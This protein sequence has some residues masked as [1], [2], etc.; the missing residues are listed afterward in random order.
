MLNASLLHS[1]GKALA[2]LRPRMSV[3]DAI[4][5]SSREIS[6]IIGVIDEIASQTSLLALM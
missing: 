3:M 6:N 2:E 1:F 4:D 5:G